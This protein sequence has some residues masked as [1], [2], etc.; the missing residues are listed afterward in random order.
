MKL[1]III[2]SDPKNGEEA[3]GRALHALALAAEAQEK[4]DEVN[5][6][7]SGAGTR[8]PAELT[9]LTHPANGL[10]NAVRP[11]IT[12]ASCGCSAVFGTATEVAACG[13]PE[14]K[15]HAL[16]G[17]PGPR[18]HPPLPGRRLADAGVPSLPESS[19]SVARAAA[20]GT[21]KR[22]AADGEHR[23]CKSGVAADALPPKRP[24][25]VASLGNSSWNRSWF[26]ASYR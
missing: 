17:T 6:V 18:E 7:F 10:Y 24:R 14:I 19:P 21:G 3:L 23:A 1:A 5:V 16:P 4:G 13:L 12:G 26:A 15:D 11:V 2:T 9:K 8:W 25:A 22:V 20:L